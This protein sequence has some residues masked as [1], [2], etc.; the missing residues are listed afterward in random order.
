MSKTRQRKDQAY[1]EGLKDGKAGV[2]FVYKRH[3]YLSFYKKG[4]REGA[5]LRKETLESSPVAGY[6]DI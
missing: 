1:Y 6:D 3:P 4:Y 2:G 5:T